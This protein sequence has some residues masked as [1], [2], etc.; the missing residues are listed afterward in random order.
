MGS[1][2]T[3]KVSRKAALPYTSESKACR[4]AQPTPHLRYTLA[5]S[6]LIHPTLLHSGP[7]RLQIALTKCNPGTLHAFMAFLRDKLAASVEERAKAISPQTSSLPKR[8]RADLPP[9]FQDI[10]P[11]TAAEAQG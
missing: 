10:S 5:F 2:S 6:A 1:P 9:G 8:R 7:H 11:L 3:A 4:Q